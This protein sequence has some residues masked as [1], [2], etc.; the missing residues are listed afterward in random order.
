MVQI[1][2]FTDPGKD[3]DDLLATVHVIMQAKVAGIID[4][5]TPIKLITTDEI[6]C[7]K[8]GVQDPQGKYGLRALYLQMHIEQLQKQLNFPK[9]Y[10]PEV[11]AGPVTSYYSY[12]EQLKKYYHEPSQ[13][14]AFYPTD[15]VIKYYAQ[16]EVFPHI[17]SL[18]S[19][20]EQ[21]DA[22]LQQIGQASPEDT[23][24]VNIASFNAVSDFLAQMAPEE[25]KKYT[26]INLG[27]NKP[28]SQNDYQ[29]SD[30]PYNAR[31]TDTNKAALAVAALTHDNAFHVV[32]KTTRV[33]PNYSKI[34]SIKGTA[35]IMSRA[36]PV[37]TGQYAPTLLSAMG[38]FIKSSK[39][40]GFW[41]HD[42]VASLLALIGII[43]WKESI[44]TEVTK[45]MLFKETAQIPAHDL[46]LRMVNNTGVLID[47]TV[48]VDPEKKDIAIESDG[49]FIYGKEI[50][51]IFFT[52]LLHLI[53]VGC[54]KE[55]EPLVNCYKKI[56]ELKADLHHL[57]QQG[58]T[59]PEKEK[60]V[61]SLWIKAN[62]LELQQQLK[63][64]AQANLDE[65]NK[66]FL[67]AESLEAENK[68]AL[69][70]NL[71][72]WVREIEAFL[73]LIENNDLPE[74][75][76]QEINNAFQ[77]PTTEKKYTALTGLFVNMLRPR[78]MPTE[79]ACNL[80]QQN[81]K[82]GFEFKR[83][84][85]SV[86]Y[87]SL[88]TRNHLIAAF[89]NGIL[90]MS[91][92]YKELLRLE[93]HSETN[94]TAFYLH[95]ALHDA[96]KGD[97]IKRAVHRDNKGNYL[98]RLPSGNYFKCTDNQLISPA[99]AEQFERAKEYVDHDIA[100]EL[101]GFAG[102]QEN[103]CT[104]TEYLLWG[105]T[106]PKEEQKN[107][108]SFILCDELFNLCN[109]MNIAQIVQG[110]IPFA[111]IKK[112]LDLFFAAYKKNPKLAELVFVHHCYDIFGAKPSDTMVSAAG[113][114]PEIHLKINLLYKT[115]VRVAQK[116]EPGKDPAEEAYTLYRKKL[117]KS[118]PD[119]LSSDP[120]LH[121]LAIT[122][123]AQMLRCH[124]FK[125]VQNPNNK[126]ITIRDAGQYE[127]R[128]RLF[129]ES[130]DAAFHQL[131]KREQQKL[132]Q[133]L[134]N[135]GT[136]KTPAVMVK[137][138]PK[139][140]LT[141]T[142]GA[143]YA[144]ADPTDKTQ[145]AQCLTP[146]LKLYLRLY[147]YQQ[148][149]SSRYSD[150]DVDDL[151]KIMEQVFTWYKDAS[152]KE[153]DHFADL[154]FDL[155]VKGQANAFL[156]QLGDIKSKSALEQ[157]QKIQECIK[158]MG[159]RWIETENEP[160]LLNDSFLEYETRLR[161]T[162][163]HT[164]YSDL[165]KSDLDKNKKNTF[166]KE[167]LLYQ[168]NNLSQVSEWQLKTKNANGTIDSFK[169]HHDSIFAPESPNEAV[170]KALLEVLKYLIIDTQWDIGYFGGEKVKSTIG[171][172]NLIPKGMHAVLKEIE[173]AQKGLVTF[174]ETVEKVAGMIE[175]SAKKNNHGFFNKRGETTQIF[176]D[177][178]QKLLSE[179]AEESLH[180]KFVNL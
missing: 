76:I 20:A 35:D 5:L 156:T 58:K 126:K 107:K 162:P 142:T 71:L 106:A 111:G 161:T 153:K 151:A 109:E 122:R 1:V 160:A 163:I 32:S 157:M 83:T 44:G 147:E 26:L 22:W 6:P 127:A 2:F 159:Y 70:E 155:Q 134:N 98:I 130:I 149:R 179:D 124:L 27:Y 164:I 40:K 154:L 78:L 150:I 46:R 73:Q 54:V 31:S 55:K 8:Y 99:D 95:L 69:G 75:M 96:G 180:Q 100:L 120:S 39:Y 144:K 68:N 42:V 115:L 136:G 143:E 21:P 118:I 102:S 12:N 50:D 88:A 176:Y 67:S 165:Q 89:P 56:I 33:L 53:A 117:A 146:M 23:T 170:N 79:S 141:A 25:Q 85:N 86:L 59:D 132:V 90:G 113:S 9:G 104:A 11:I 16:S 166:R 123:I 101:Y 139:L 29:T 18:L 148:T 63:L 131:P 138:G 81:G 178:A 169:I 24:L 140:L 177:K 94:K 48:P 128:T 133:L 158:S 112:G 108:E 174:S 84:G 19:T 43:N 37:L 4:P 14:D 173:D 135:T 87:F 49:N 3:G 47:S 152:K 72:Q 105:G 38:E 61:N 74:S 114:S 103:N 175:I 167:F 145:I 28:Y 92:K 82:L 91:A 7:N 13:S 36:Y 97:Y 30:L 119:I 45:E 80:L 172:P 60:Q 51:P 168:L 77:Q 41:P 64:Q 93:G 62:L 129:V 10:L 110:E 34:T 121:D 137:Y 171:A 65:A 116:Q 15:E 52:S 66:Y 125:T 57:K 17:N